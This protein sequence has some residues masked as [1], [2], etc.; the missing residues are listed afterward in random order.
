MTRA[1]RFMLLGLAV[2]IVIATGCGGGSDTCQ[3]ATSA[4]IFGLGRPTYSV[5]EVVHAFR[6]VGIDLEH[7]AIGGC[8]HLYGTSLVLT[9]D[10]CP[11]DVPATGM[12]VVVGTDWLHRYTKRNVLVRYFG[13]PGSGEKR[14][15]VAKISEALRSLEPGDVTYITIRSRGTLSLVEETHEP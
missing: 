3:T 8:P 7:R 9:V 1:L 4:P 11:R 10:V 5:D 2:V 13:S 14:G 12:V 15:V 6:G